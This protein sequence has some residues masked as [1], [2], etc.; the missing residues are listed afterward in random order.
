MKPKI[1]FSYGFFVLIWIRPTFKYKSIN[2]RLS[3]RLFIVIKTFLLADSCSLLSF[4]V[5]VPRLALGF[6]QLANAITRNT[7]NF[8]FTEEKSRT[9]MMSQSPVTWRSSRTT[10]VVTATWASTSTLNFISDFLKLSEL[11][12]EMSERPCCRHRVP[13]PVQALQLLSQLKFWKV[14]LSLLYHPENP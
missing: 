2:Q 14:R 13:F 5:V 8:G 1:I 9:Y 10:L 3:V 6:W 4:W 12:F 7:E 11:T